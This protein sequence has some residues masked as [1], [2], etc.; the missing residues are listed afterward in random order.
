MTR[1]I[2]SKIPKR[3][4]GVMISGTFTDL[5]EHRYALAH[6]IEAADLHVVSMEKDQL[7]PDT[8]ILRASLEMV[9]QAAAFIVLIS[10]KYG[11][12]PQDPERNPHGY[13]LTELEFRRA[14]ELNLPILLFVMG[15]NHLVKAADVERVPE[16][17]KKL[18]GFLAFAK[19][20]SPGTNVERKYYEFEDL[21]SFG[22]VV[23]AACSNLRT[24]L[25]SVPTEA[26]DEILNFTESV[27]SFRLTPTAIAPELCAVPRYLGSH[28]LVGRQAELSQLSRWATSD[29]SVLLI[30]DA[31]GGAGKSLL[32]WSW[33]NDHALKV[34]NRWAGRFWYSF[35]ENHAQMADFCSQALAYFL[36]Q[37]PESFQGKTAQE[38]QDLLLFHLERSRWLIVLDGLER[39]LAP[40]DAAHVSDDE[41]DRLAKQDPCRAIR[42]EDE[43]LL[44]ALAAPSHSKI[45]IT[46][47][48]VP[49]AF[50]NRSGQLIPGV[51]RIP[52]GGLLPQ[53]AEYMLRDCGVSGNAQDIRQ[54]LEENWD[55]HPLAIGVIAGLINDYLPAPGNFD[56]WLNA[57]HEEGILDFVSLDLV[58]RCNHILEVA[59]ARLSKDSE[60]VLAS[61]ALVESGVDIEALKNLNPQ[62]SHPLDKESHFFA[63]NSELDRTIRSLDRQGLLQYDS[64]SRRHGLHP[65]VRTAVVKRLNLQER[66]HLGKRVCNYLIEQADKAARTG[67]RPEEV[68][69]CLNIMRVNC[70][71]EAFYLEEGWKIYEKRLQGKLVYGREEYSECSAALR[72]IA[73]GTRGR[74]NFRTLSMQV[75][76]ELAILLQMRDKNDEALACLDE[77]I[78]IALQLGL[79]AD[80]NRIASNISQSLIRINSLARSHRLAQR[81]TDLAQACESDKESLF[82]AKMN[83]FHV[84]ALLGRWDQA[85]ELWIELS[86]LKR[87]N[88]GPGYRTGTAEFY[89]AEFQLYRG[90]LSE[91]VLTVAEDLAAI[92]G[93]RSNLA[94]RIHQLR[95]KWL[96]ARGLWAEAL[97]SLETSV[98]IAKDIGMRDPK[99]EARMALAKFHLG[100]LKDAEVETDRLS[101]I[102]GCD[103]HAL[104]CLWLS[105]GHLERA[106]F[107]SW[108]SYA[109]AWADGEP[110]VRRFHLAKARELFKLMGERSPELKPYDGAAAPPGW[111]HLLLNLTK[112]RLADRVGTKL[113]QRELFGD[114]ATVSNGESW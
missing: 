22:L 59:L 61:L 81:V 56:R 35:Y 107:H 20:Y 101:T 84:L 63:G 77:A 103:H 8:D 66:T 12:I 24:Y 28:K 15:S 69:L 43:S 29:Q 17:I 47:R 71:M 1:S 9:E 27:E 76:N 113:H 53:D 13:S 92:G 42:T 73:R 3:Y 82:I 68:R 104:A 11:H 112:K 62:L 80:V 64:A 50:V 16:N 70:L 88:P 95:A 105:L 55:C 114:I 99:A 79:T 7:R 14:V 48:L 111:E 110:F 45:L 26:T 5:K 106:R 37:K 34:S 31:I 44:R 4:L 93:W 57:V 54:Y 6:A 32:A 21:E 90:N 60:A 102:P 108:K 30:D 87:P 98:Q 46:S 75:N 97:G 109:W 33:I 89:F 40:Y 39:I 100:S 67:D 19:Q 94:R 25:E 65:V 36:G 49:Q 52:L 91:E 83:Y 10:H 58:N 96:M 86:A 41:A 51:D 78:E 18:E 72:A 85:E 74:E 23:H 2:S 38:L